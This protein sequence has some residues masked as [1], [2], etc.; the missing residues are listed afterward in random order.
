VIDWFLPA[1]KAGG[2]VQSIANLVE[3]YQ[4]PETNFRIFCGN[5]DLD[6]SELK[7]VAFDCWTTYNSYTQVWYASKKS[8]S[9]KT[10]RKEIKDSAA[11]IL[12]I[13]GIYSWYFNIVPLLFGDTKIKILSVRGMLH[14]GALSQK[15]LKKKIY[16]AFLKLFRVQHRVHFHATDEQEALFIKDVFGTRVQ[17]FRAGNFPRLSATQPALIKEAG[18]LRMVSIA[19][20]SPMKN[21]ALV[22]Q[23]LKHCT[24]QI[25]YDIYGPVKD[26]NYWQECVALIQQLP[27]NIKVQYKGAIEPAKTAA[28]LHLYDIFILPSKSENFGHAIYE[29]LSSGKPVITSYNTPWNGL[30]EAKAGINVSM[31]VEPLTNAINFF[32]AFNN[33]KYQ[34][35]ATAAAA[36]A[37]KKIDLDNIQEAYSTMFQHSSKF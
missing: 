7:G 1:Y 22:L 34:Q 4:W 18:L 14:P 5:T 12:F 6:D 19:L 10:I 32:A 11:T 23:S 20:I 29:A 16:L 17:I 3:Q 37:A 21:I 35:W 26:K 15:P 25:V 33:E 36:Y 2:P 8:K 31:S 9:V 24:Q 27:L 28:T 13:I 30:E